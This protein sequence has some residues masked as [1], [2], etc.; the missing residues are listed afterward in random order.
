MNTNFIAIPFEGY[1]EMLEK[2]GKLDEI[3]ELMRQY[4]YEERT[5]PGPSYMHNNRCRLLV[6][7]IEWAMKKELGPTVEECPYAE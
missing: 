5:N 7:D 2:I 3:I 4:Q 6:H 1:Q